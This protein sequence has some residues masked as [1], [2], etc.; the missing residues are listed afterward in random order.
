M[1]KIAFISLSR[2]DYQ[3]LSPIY[4]EFKKNGFFS[5]DLICG[6]SHLLSRYGRSFE[7]VKSQFI[8]AKAK[9]N[10]LSQMDDNPAELVDASARLMHQFNDYLDDSAPDA[11]FIV[12]DRWELLPIAFASFLRRIPLIHHSGGDITQ[13]SMDNQL[14][15]SVTNLAN[16]HFVAIDQHRRRLIETGEEGWRI[17]VVGEPA[18]QSAEKLVNTPKKKYSHTLAT[19][20][21]CVVDYLDIPKQVDFFIEC[22]K[23]IPGKIIV[24]GPN[25][26]AY[27]EVVYQK[28]KT[29]VANQPN[30]EF[31]E[32]LGVQYYDI[33]KNS[34]LIIGNSSSGI[35]EAA[36]FGVPA[37][38]IGTRQEGRTR[39][40]N[41][42]DISYSYE[43]FTNAVTQTKSWQFQ[44]SISNMSNIYFDKNSAKKIYSV[45]KKEINNPNLLKKRVML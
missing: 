2:S 5:I 12:G 27:S 19:F 34:S 32:N 40:A 1:K 36:T 38:N 3:T 45:V 8:E 21:P 30:V 28:L 11:I 13:G 6:G 25:P 18:L 42:I 41:I 26:D 29:F 9:L 35:W 20:H 7:E 37:I 15:Y 44:Q 14:R 17:H 24:T 33:L 4:A 43:S 31:R 22:L 16:L 23:S 39:Q 10:F